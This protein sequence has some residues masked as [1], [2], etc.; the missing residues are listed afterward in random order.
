M[1][2]RRILITGSRNWDD[3]AVIRTA[4]ATVWAPDAVLVSG[5]NPHGADALCEACWSHWGGHVE[6]HLADWDRFGTSAGL[7][8]N[9]QMV[10]LGADAC[11]AF[12]RDNSRGATHT[13]DL[14][15]EAGIPTQRIHWTRDIAS[16]RNPAHQESSIVRPPIPTPMLRIPH[17]AEA[18]KRH[19]TEERV[20]WV[21]APTPEVKTPG[22]TVGQW[23]RSGERLADFTAGASNAVADA[24]ARDTEREGAE[25]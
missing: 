20:I 22:R 24:M 23:L 18:A 5:A 16:G 2:T 17:L 3:P 1:R 21:D 8:R 6:R 13:A 19:G 7:R 11:L 25:R 12:I 14:A 15:E 4:L 10:Q 9:A